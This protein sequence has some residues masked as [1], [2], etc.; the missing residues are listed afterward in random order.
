MA[1]LAQARAIGARRTLGVALCAAGTVQAGKE[2]L[3]LLEEAA[4]VLQDSPARLEH[5][6]A[7]ISLGAG[8]RRGGH[9]VAGREPLRRGLEIA[10]SAGARPLAG[11]AGDELRAAGGRPSA[12]RRVSERVLSP[13]EDRV[14]RLAARGLSTP[15]IAQTLYLARKTVDW[16]LGNAFRKLGITSRH[17][18]PGALAGWR[19]EDGSPSLTH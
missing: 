9:A 8:L 19:R 10:R 6:R 3:R 2:G 18:L 4:Q 17:D 1:E 12:S 13:A 5:A 16:H 14:V 11:Y 7:L 15:Q